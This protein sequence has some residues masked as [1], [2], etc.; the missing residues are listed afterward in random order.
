MKSLSAAVKQLIHVGAAL[1]ALSSQRFSSVDAFIKCWDGE[2]VEDLQQCPY[3]FDAWVGEIKA[4]IEPSGVIG[5]MLIGNDLNNDNGIFVATNAT[6]FPQSITNGTLTIS[7]S[8]S[9]EDC[10]SDALD[11]A[12]EIPLEKPVTYEINSLRGIEGE[13]GWFQQPIRE[14]SRENS[15]LPVSLDELVSGSGSDY[16]LA[17]YLLSSDEEL[18]GCASLKKLDNE[19]AAVYDELLDSLSQ[20]QEAAKGVPSSGSNI[21]L[22]VVSAIVAVGIAVVL[23]DALAL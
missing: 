7:I 22:F 13:G 8:D 9:E 18:L 6:N 3:A 1:L 17:V 16:G 12:S 20:D 10:N 4:P 5:H 11:R 15:T 19:K 23:G 21:G 14:M 2:M